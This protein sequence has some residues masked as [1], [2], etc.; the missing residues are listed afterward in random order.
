MSTVQTAI[1]IRPFHVDIAEEKLSEL[2]DRIAGTRWPSGELVTDRS[3]GVQLATI[4]ELTRYFGRG[5]RL[6]HGRGEAERAAAVHDRD[7]RRGHPL[8]PRALAARGRVAADHDPRLARLC[9]RDDRLGRPGDRTD[10]ARRQRR[11]CLPSRSA[12]PARIRLLSRAGRD[13]LGIGPDRTGLGR[14]T[15]AP[16]RVWPLRGP[17]RRRRRRRHRHDGPPGTRGSDRH[18]HEPARS[19]AQRPH[20]DGHRRGTRRGRTDRHLPAVRKRL[21]RRNGDPPADDRLRPARFPHRPG[22]LDGRPRHGRL[23]QDRARLRRRAAL[24]QPHTRP[25]PRQHHAVLADRHRRL[26]GTVV[27]GGLRPRRPGR[28]PTAPAAASDP[29]RL[30]DVPRRD[31]ADAAQLGRGELPERHLL[32][33]GQTRAATSPPGKSR[34]LFSSELRAAFRS[35]R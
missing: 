27:L 22:R 23:L 20:A 13:R 34:R 19:G 10:R 32:Q 30:H 15:H 6:R 8:R 14:R 25:H 35:V 2:R 24:G 26:R 3:Q 1:D 29:G 33:R 31:L 4:K 28:E 11:G 9:D 12:L 7:R 17:G 18:P 5:V 16:P 21:L